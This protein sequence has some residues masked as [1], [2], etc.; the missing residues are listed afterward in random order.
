MLSAWPSVQVLLAYHG[1]GWIHCLLSDIERL[2]AGKARRSKE[3]IF[4]QQQ[5]RVFSTVTLA[6][7]E[8]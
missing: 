6:V 7:E 1:V 2:P 3:E 4:E 8:T 5:E